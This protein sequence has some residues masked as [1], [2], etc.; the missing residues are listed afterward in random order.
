MGALIKK[1]K[2][3][4]EGIV[5]KRRDLPYRSGLS[6]RRRNRPLLPP[7]SSKLAGLSLQGPEETCQLR[8]T[9]SAVGSIL[10]GRN[11]CLHH[12]VVTGR[13]REPVRKVAS[14]FG[15]LLGRKRRSGLQPLAEA[16]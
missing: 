4:S 12:R 9:M 3:G 10:A 14:Q 13:R 2:L 11:V 6:I 7:Q 16:Q 5:S 15:Q 8:P 1:A